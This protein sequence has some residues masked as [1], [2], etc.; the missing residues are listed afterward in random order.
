MAKIPLPLPQSTATID[1]IY[2]L[3]L[4]NNVVWE[5]DQLMDR[6]PPRSKMRSPWLTGNH[7]IIPIDMITAARLHLIKPGDDSGIGDEQWAWIRLIG[8][9]G[10]SA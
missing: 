4:P 3:Y 6:E 7:M 5:F 8:L 10:E 9:T 2:H 1:V